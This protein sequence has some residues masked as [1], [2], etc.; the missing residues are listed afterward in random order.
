MNHSLQRHLSSVLGLVIVV[1]GL[2][3]TTASFLLAYDEAR[4]FQDDM[5]RQI[6]VLTARSDPATAARTAAETLIDDPESRVLVIR[7]PGS[8]RPDWL[9]DRLPAGFHTLNRRGEELR[10]F[11]HQEGSPKTETIIAQPTDARDEIAINSA[12]R[13]LIP[14]LLVFPLLIFAI[15]RIVRREFNPVIELARDLDAQAVDRPRAI[16]V[17]GLPSEITP[18]VQ[19]INRLLG[20]VNQLLD[21]QR[22]FIADAAHELRSPLT[23]LSVQ[24]Q[25]LSQAGS[26][27]AMRERIAPLQAGI[28]RARQLSEQ[29][30]SLARI[31]A[32]CGTESIVDI[33]ALARELIADYLPTAESK[34]IDL[35]LDE[36]AKFT[37]PAA[38]ESLRLI[39]GNALDNA[40]KYS[41][42]GGEVTLRLSTD[43]DTAII[44]V[45][46]DGPGI[47]PDECER[48]F[49]A[50]Y[51]I[52]G[53]YESGSGLG[54][55]IAREAAMRLGG[56]VSLSNRKDRSGAIFTYR[57]GLTR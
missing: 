17:E 36:D 55:A 46:D 19:A 31:Q 26:L 6:A 3:A 32:G 34:G 7:L 21:Q 42:A 53:T 33:S 51:R 22:R 15:V 9:P 47:P 49:D 35:G 48:V 18:F 12:L 25:N 27:D 57:Q 54:L 52:A 13:T 24:A 40:L 45:L 20:R 11:V 39:V 28:E 8:P 23:A 14:L 37:L 4:E 56:S 44:E 38:P 43:N 30:L 41:R 10:I 29:L 16:E 5:L 1:F 50:F 2:A